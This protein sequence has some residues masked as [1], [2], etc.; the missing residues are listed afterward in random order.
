MKNKNI[1]TVCITALLTAAVFILTAYLHIPTHTGYTHVGDALIYFS[2]CILPVP[3]AIFVGATGALLADCLTGF[4]IWAPASVIIKSLS[5]V[6]FSKNTKR[7]LCKRNVLALIPAAVIS[8]GGY[9]LYD[10]AIL[11]SF[12]AALPGVIGYITQAALSS[13]LFLVLAPAADKAGIKRILQNG[14]NEK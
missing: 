2:A 12:A 1:L 4:A 13:A 5:A 10:A 3:Y 11:G 7:I 14:D 8:I 9:Y 6:L